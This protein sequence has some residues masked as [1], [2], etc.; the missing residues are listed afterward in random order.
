MKAQELQDLHSALKW[1]RRNIGP[2]FSHC[3]G[4]PKCLFESPH[5]SFGGE[6]TYLLLRLQNLKNNLIAPSRFKALTIHSIILLSPS[7]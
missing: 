5:W 3:H 6:I 2:E 7:L 4:G 1:Y